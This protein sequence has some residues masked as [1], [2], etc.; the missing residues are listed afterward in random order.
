MYPQVK[1]SDELQ[2]PSSIGRLIRRFRVQ[3]PRSTPTGRPT[4]EL[5]AHRAEKAVAVPT[6]YASIYSESSLLTRLTSTQIRGMRARRKALDSREAGQGAEQ[7]IP[8][9]RR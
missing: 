3:I 4:D 7:E 5:P 1:D 6:H 8:F 2:R 9:H